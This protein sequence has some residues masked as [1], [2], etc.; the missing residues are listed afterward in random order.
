MFYQIAGKVAAPLSKTNEIV[1][2]SGE[3]SRVTGEVTRLLAELPVSINALTGV[4]LTKVRLALFSTIMNISH[5]TA[6]VNP[7]FPLSSESAGFLSFDCCKILVFEHKASSFYCCLLQIKNINNSWPD[8]HKCSIL[9]RFSLHVGLSFT[10]SGTF[11]LTSTNAAGSQTSHKT[12]SFSSRLHISF[13]LY[14]I[15]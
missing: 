6:L 14:Q 8:N 1:I 9:P 3:G 15:L 2:L 13:N 10:C 12:R 11:Q 4:D 7:Y 5:Q